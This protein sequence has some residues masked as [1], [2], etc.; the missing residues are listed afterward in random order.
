M[1]VMNTV[2]VWAWVGMSVNA[3]NGCCDSPTLFTG[4]LESLQGVL[5]LNSTYILSY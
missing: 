2:C 4:K 5:Y 1:L 3:V